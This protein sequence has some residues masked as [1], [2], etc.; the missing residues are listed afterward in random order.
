[1]ASYARR[2]GHAGGG[3]LSPFP[4]RRAAPAGLRRGPHGV[5]TD[6]LPHVIEDPAHPPFLFPRT[7]DLGGDRAR[8]SILS[9]V[10][11]RLLLMIVV[12]A[13]TAPVLGGGR[14]SPVLIAV[15]SR[16]AGIPVGGMSYEQAQAIV[17][18]RVRAT[19]PAFAGPGTLERRFVSL[20]GVGDGH[21]RPVQGLRGGSRRCRRPRPRDSTRR[22]SRATRWAGEAPSRT[23][24]RTPSS[25]G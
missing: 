19:T 12:V 1:M 21:G 17:G 24:P 4:L 23:P 5:R 14:G 8:S 22:R 16:S 18:P 2:R 25:S 20:R 10:I 11:R 6:C 9:S 13:A 15:T 3:G 7:R